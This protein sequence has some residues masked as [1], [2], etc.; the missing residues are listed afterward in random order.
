MRP[1]VD[2]AFAGYWQRPDADAKAIRD[3][4]YHT[5]DI[6]RV[7]E[8]GD[9]WIDGR[10]DDMII[11]GG[12][13]IHPLE[14]ENVLAR[15]PGVAEV[16]VVGAADERLGQR[17]VAVVVGDGDARRSS[18]PTASPRTLARFKRPREYRFVDEL[19]K[20][21][22]ARSCGGNS[23]E[24]AE[25]VS[26]FDGFRVERDGERRDDHPRRP[27]QVQPRVDARARP[28]RAVFDELDGDDGG[29][30]RRPH[31]RGR[32]LHRRRRH[33]RIP[34]GLAWAVSKLACNVAAPER[35]SKPVIAELRGYVFGVGFELALAC[36][37]RIAT[38]DVELAFPRR[39]SG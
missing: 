24:E 21:S 26:G 12:E 17:V 33:R 37:F 4:W 31:R 6:G 22:S 32:R 29:S 10:V 14:V 38:D 13:N 35:C 28:A 2:E 18:T 7:D 36:D 20:S 39:R 25:G 30:L 8:D 16:A 15:H 3:G 19:P 34:R 9:L 23:R 11:S 1:R 27:G 5:G